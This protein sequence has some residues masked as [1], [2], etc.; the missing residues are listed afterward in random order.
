MFHQG[1]NY[2]NVEWKSHVLL[3]RAVENDQNSAAGVAHHPGR[4]ANQQTSYVYSY[5][6]WEM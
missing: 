2:I 6:N 4:P 3:L 5:D 1:A